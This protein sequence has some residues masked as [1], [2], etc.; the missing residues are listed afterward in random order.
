MGEEAH[1]HSYFHPTF[2]V[3]IEFSLN[4]VKLA[5]GQSGY[6]EFVCANVGDDVVTVGNCFLSCSHI[7]MSPHQYE[8]YVNVFC[9]KLRP[10]DQE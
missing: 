5:P 10:I 6:S 3:D 2:T 7:M 9:R 4:G 8:V 1:I